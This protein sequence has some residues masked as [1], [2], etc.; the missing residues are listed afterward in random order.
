MMT[1][2]RRVSPKFNV[3]LSGYGLMR[4]MPPSPAT[5]ASPSDE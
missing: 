1:I 2:L 4:L 3:V 5:S